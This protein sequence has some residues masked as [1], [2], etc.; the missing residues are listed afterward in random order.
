MLHELPSA[1]EAASRRVPV[2][3]AAR[4]VYERVG[5][6]VDARRPKCDLSGRCCR[7][8]DYG[9][10]LYVTTIELAAFIAELRGVAVASPRTPVRSPGVEGLRDDDLAVLVASPRTPVRS[11][12]GCPFQVDRLCGVHAIRP[13]GCRIFF[14][15]PRA[16]DW[17]V[18]QYEQF[19]SQLRLLHE[20]WDVP[21]FYVEWRAALEALGLGG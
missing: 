18:E 19:H 16:A 12:G 5:A 13:F 1:V 2:V 3:E 21:Y 6:A 14:C 17:Q 10:R 4:Q 9:H 7:F 8:D 15:D 20:T 11:P